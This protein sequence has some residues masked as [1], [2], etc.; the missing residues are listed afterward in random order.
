MIVHVSLIH[1]T[2]QGDLL[3]RLNERL[4]VEPLRQPFVVNTAM[5]HNL[6]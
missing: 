2:L 3:D 4:S 1:S 5:L 6:K